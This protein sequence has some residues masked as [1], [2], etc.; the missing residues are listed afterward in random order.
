MFPIGDYNP[1]LR[2]PVVTYALIFVMGAAWLF[3]QGAGVDA[4]AFAS[5]ICELG[6]IPGELTDSATVGT[7]VP[8]GEGV[9][10]VVADRGWLD[11]LTLLT[12]MFLHG[13]WLHIIGNAWFLRIF[14]DNV[15]DGMGRGRFLVFYLGVA[16]SRRSPRWASTRARR[17]RS[18]A[19]RAPSRG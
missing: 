4:Q 2:T 8:L 13:S 10:C 1:R 5:S 9:A 3:V 11:P 17:C 12:S 15:E 16:S 14:G 18:S 19:H 6:P 7:Q